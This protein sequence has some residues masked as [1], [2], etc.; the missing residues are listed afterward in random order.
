MI[1]FKKIY[2]KNKILKFPNFIPI[3]NINLIYRSLYIFQ[4]YQTDP[5]ILKNGIFS[6]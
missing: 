6:S 2:I 3:F 1:F 5:K 4:K